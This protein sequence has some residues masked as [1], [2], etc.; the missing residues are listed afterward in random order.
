MEQKLKDYKLLV[1]LVTVNLLFCTFHRHID[2]DIDIDINNK[3]L[4]SYI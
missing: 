2:I 3:Y 4:K 1:S